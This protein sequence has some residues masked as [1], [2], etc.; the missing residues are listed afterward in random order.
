M[1]LAITV[2]KGDTFTIGDQKFTVQDIQRGAG[3]T[4]EDPEGRAVQVGQ[5]APVAVM[6]GVT[7]LDGPRVLA[8]KARL[9]ID[10]PKTIKIIR[11]DWREPAVEETTL[12]D[13]ALL[14]S[15]PIEHL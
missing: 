5:D 7:L 14:A 11:G 9:V 6:R 2:A 1:G 3:L 8:G 13:V 4:I 12:A 10:A 15:V